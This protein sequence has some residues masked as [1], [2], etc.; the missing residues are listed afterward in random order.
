MSS[1]RPALLE[2]LTGGDRRS[3][4]EADRVVDQILAASSRFGEIV[5]GLGDPDAVVRVRAADVAE[6]VSRVRPDLL[7][8]YKDTLLRLIATSA[9]KEVRWHLAQ[10]APRVPLGADERRF[11][12]GRLFAWLDD[13]SRIVQASALTALADLS[14]DDPALRARV[15]GLAQTLASSA[16]PALR[17]RARKV[18]ARLRKER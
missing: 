4:G 13:P 8:S 10:I 9:D 12:V 15:A 16:S 7:A 11:C 1:G 17:A 2:A 18:C 5:A 3:I 14:A 6:K